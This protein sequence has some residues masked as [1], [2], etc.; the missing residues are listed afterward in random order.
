MTDSQQDAIRH[1]L[2]ACRVVAAVGFNGRDRTKPA[3]YVPVY[4]KDRGSRS[5][6]L[7]PD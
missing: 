5:S 1:I 2:T 3:C 7:A 6:P 4:L